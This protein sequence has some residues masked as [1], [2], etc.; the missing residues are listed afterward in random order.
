MLEIGRDRYHCL[1]FPCN[2]YINIFNNTSS[3]W[4]PSWFMYLWNSIKCCVRRSWSSPLNLGRKSP[5]S[6]IVGT[7]F[8]KSRTTKKFKGANLVAIMAS[9]VFYILNR[10]SRQY[11]FPPWICWWKNCSLNPVTNPCSPSNIGYN[12]FQY[13][14]RE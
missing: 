12:H 9:I 2:E 11:F 3:W 7:S 5:H 4:I 8:G 10:W 1:A 14:T 13:W 6:S